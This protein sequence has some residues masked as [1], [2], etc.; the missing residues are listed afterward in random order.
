MSLTQDKIR[1]VDVKKDP[2]FTESKWVDTKLDKTLVANIQAQGKDGKLLE[3][4]TKVQ[5]S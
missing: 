2:R 4:Q 3:V 5:S 1:V